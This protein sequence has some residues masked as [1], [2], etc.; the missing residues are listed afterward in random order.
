MKWIATTANFFFPGLGNIISGHQ[1]CL[2]VGW[3]LGFIGLTYVELSLQEPMPAL[4]WTMF[5]SVLLI[6]SM[7][8]INLFQALSAKE[9]PVERPA[10]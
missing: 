9:V 8:A 5:A 4:Y 7:F 2:G 10:S 6:N 1:R 3:L